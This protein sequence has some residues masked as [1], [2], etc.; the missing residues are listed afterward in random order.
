MRSKRAMRVRINFGF[1]KIDLSCVVLTLNEQRR[2]RQKSMHNA[3]WQRVAFECR[4]EPF[5][6]LIISSFYAF[7]WQ[8]SSSL[9]QSDSPMSSQSISFVCFSRDESVAETH[10]ASGSCEESHKLLRNW[11]SNQRRN[12][13][14]RR[15]KRSTFRW[16]YRKNSSSENVDF[17]PDDDSVNKCDAIVVVI[18]RLSP[19]PKSSEI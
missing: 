13:S 2:T 16:N 15:T 9:R 8:I 5:K 19:L 12:A 1:F 10:S 6:L 17:L 3:K 4:T 11:H 14:H 7:G 18:V